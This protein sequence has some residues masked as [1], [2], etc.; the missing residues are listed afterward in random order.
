MDEPERQQEIIDYIYEH[1][2]ASCRSVAD[3]LGIASH[4]SV[5]H[6]LRRENL[7]PFRY[8]TVQRLTPTDHNPRDQFSRWMLNHVREDRDF[9]SFILFTDEA[10]FTQEGVFNQHN[11]HQWREENPHAIREHGFQHR[12]SVNVWAGILGDHII[13]PHIFPGHHDRRNVQCFS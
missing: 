6:V 4:L 12:Y 11:L 9:S 2:N 5:R 10:Q 7:H 1:P 8:Q 3:A 13:G